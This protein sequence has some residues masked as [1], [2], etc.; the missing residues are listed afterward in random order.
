MLSQRNIFECPFD[1]SFHAK[2]IKS[3]SYFKYNVIRYKFQRNADNMK[4]LTPVFLEIIITN[5]FLQMYIH[6]IMCKVTGTGWHLIWELM[7]EIAQGAESHLSF[8]MLKSICK[9]L[10]LYL[11]NGRLNLI[12]GEVYK[13]KKMKSQPRSG[14]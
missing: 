11:Y 1:F 6:N 5:Y 10:L 2:C 14:R 13:T 8:V 4:F 12:L 7:K 9:N 3:L